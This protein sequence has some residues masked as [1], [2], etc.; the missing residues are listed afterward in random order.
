MDIKSIALSAVIGCVG[1][2]GISS[3][4]IKSQQ[5]NLEERLIKSPPIV[6]VDF[7]K[8]AMQY[9]EGA[10]PEEVESLMMKTN[11]A[12][13]KLR[14]AGYL[15]LDAGA[16]VSAPEDVYLPEDFLK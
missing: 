11:E 13:I 8:M 6:V 3:M 15:V 16:V 9:P 14:E 1:G 4:L 7:A 10:S 12:V 5:D 2:A